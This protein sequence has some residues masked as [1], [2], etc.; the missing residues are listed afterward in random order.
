MHGLP[1]YQGTLFA[2]KSARGVFNDGLR[3]PRACIVSVRTSERLHRPSNIIVFSYD[4]GSLVPEQM[5]SL[6]FQQTS[7]RRSPNPN[8]QR[9]ESFLLAVRGI[10][11][12]CTTD[13]SA[14]SRVELPHS[15]HKRA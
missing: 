11:G 14:L 1:A 13:L 6:Y 3:R 8:L 4:S 5:I 12:S 9:A 10:L 15:Q 7:D 2:A